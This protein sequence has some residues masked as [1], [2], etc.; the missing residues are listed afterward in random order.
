MTLHGQRVALPETTVPTRY[1]SLTVMIDPRSLKVSLE[2]PVSDTQAFFRGRVSSIRE[3]GG[4]VWLEI[5]CGD[6]LTAIV[7][8]ANYEEEGLNLHRP[9]VVSFG[10]D[11]VEV[12]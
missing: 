9:V 3:L 11:A 4:D 7:S 2:P 1:G 10:P 12:L 8:R 6:R 5:D